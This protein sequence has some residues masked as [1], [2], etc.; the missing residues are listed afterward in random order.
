MENK[1][2]Q[3]LARDESRLRGTMGRMEHKGKAKFTNKPSG[4]KM[5]R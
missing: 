4:G 2:K 3:K 1:T 5:A